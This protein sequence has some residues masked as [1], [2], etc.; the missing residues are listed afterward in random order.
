MSTVKSEC[1]QGGKPTE[2]SDSSRGQHWELR[3]GRGPRWLRVVRSSEEGREGHWK[4]RWWKSCERRD[5]RCSKLQALQLLEDRQQCV[6]RQRDAHRGRT[7]SHG[8]CIEL[9]QPTFRRWQD[10]GCVVEW[11]SKIADG[12][13]LVGWHQSVWR[14]S[15]ERREKILAGMSAKFW[16]PCERLEKSF[17]GWQSMRVWAAGTGVP[18]KLMAC[19]V[20]AGSGSI[21]W[22]VSRASTAAGTGVESAGRSASLAEAVKSPGVDSAV[23]HVFAAN[24]MAHEAVARVESATERSSNVFVARTGTSEAGSVNSKVMGLLVNDLIEV[25][26]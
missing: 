15:S 21:V 20:T 25:G 12:I 2:E 8:L 22:V 13:L 16:L 3:S 5:L 7:T 14:G 23:N 10:D 18:G 9:L 19:R 11:L 6:C 17:L 24:R 4:H 26:G 1:R